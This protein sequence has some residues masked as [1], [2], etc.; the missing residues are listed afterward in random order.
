MAADSKTEKATPKKRRDERKEGNVLSSN[1][2]VNVVCVFGG[3][4]IFSFLF[5]GMYNNISSFMVRYVSVA[6]TVDE[7]S[8]GRLQEIGLDFMVTV[9]KTIVPFMLIC[10][11]LAILSTG[12]QTKFLFA[13]KNYKPKFSR[14]SPLQG[15]KK[16][17]SLK[18]II[19]LVKNILKII[20]LI[21][22][23]YSILKKDI[24]NVIRT[25]DMDIKVS[26]T[27]M[28]DLTM[29]M[30]LKVAMVFIVVAGLDFLYQWWDYERRIKMSK[31]ELK[32]EYKQ[33]EGNPEIKGRIRDIQRQRAK[34]RMMQAVPE[35]DV[36][37]RNPTHFAVALKYDIDH[38]NAPIVVAKG[39]DELA[40]RIIR[41]GEENSVTI[42]EN[43][44][45]ARAI[46]AQSEV[47]HEIPAEYYG[48]VAEILIYVYK[49]NKT[50]E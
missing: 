40:L 17:F 10:V 9:A 20:I 21:A 33:T 24:I 36:I 34:A 25:M 4:I 32:E 50:M 5:P 45:L 41:V 7:L 48:A 23:V 35:A 26:S 3:F 42:V 14:L 18:N 6:G 46:F 37:I 1:D 16:L 8:I 29:E 31:Q 11:A 43:R 13:S 30:I 19:E 47:G 39:Q 38:D 49:M 22:V 2:I 15:I 12:V 27:Y 44:P 28:L